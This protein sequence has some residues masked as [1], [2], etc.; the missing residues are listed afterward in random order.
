MSC[1]IV[2][3]LSLFMYFRPWL[4]GPG[5]I[6]IFHLESPSWWGITGCSVQE[7]SLCCRDVIFS[8]NL[9][10]LRLWC[11]LDLQNQENGRVLP[12]P[13]SLAMTWS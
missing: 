6:S 8:V 2:L 7:K 13:L 3:H 9:I 12:N 10:T 11:R 4:D 5:S 1:Q